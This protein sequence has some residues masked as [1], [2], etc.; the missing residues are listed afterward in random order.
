M[1]DLLPHVFGCH[2]IVK[3][4]I[5]RADGIYLYDKDGKRY[6]DFEAG[7]WCAAL[8]HNHP[9]IKHRIT[10]QISQVVHLAPQLTSNLA[11][12][13]T[14]ALLEHTSFPDGK[15]VFLSSGS[16]AVELGIKIALLYTQKKKLLTFSRSY[17]GA[18]GFAGKGLSPDCWA[19]VDIG[20][21]VK[22]PKEKCGVSCPH[23]AAFRL[24]ETAAFVTE[25]VLASGGMIAP[26]AKVVS[27]LANEVR[28]SGGLVVV[29]EVTTGLGRTGKWLGIEHFEIES[30]I[31]AFGKALGNGYPVSAVA[32]K[33]EIAERVEGEGFYYVQSHQN[34]PL[35]CAIAKEV[36]A[37][38]HESNL[39]SRTKESGKYLGDCLRKLAE[40]H[41]VVSDVR[42]LGLVYGMELK[43]DYFDDARS[44]EKIFDM[45]LERGIVIG[46]RPKQHLLRF[47][48]PLV[49]GEED[50]LSMCEC[51]GDVLTEIDNCGV[52]RSG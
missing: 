25:P 3:T 18:Y 47:L 6:V 26:P 45:M 1:V 43:A 19:Q 42:G 35:G 34:D 4:D 23:L 17:L 16:E 40:D 29:D 48:P 32:M 15:A 8:G 7:I 11:E 36:I 49:I 21:C 37:V 41:T 14:T 38:L 5:V 33:R 9:R 27:F 22:C 46:V 44:F 12:E 39:I 50:I 20:A 2:S 24:D 28:R 51:L 52:G 30:D 10:E 13:A 31:S